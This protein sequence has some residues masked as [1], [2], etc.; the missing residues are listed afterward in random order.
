MK[1]ILLV[2]GVLFL[3]FQTTAQSGQSYTYYY[4]LGL[5]AYQ[6]KEFKKADSLFTRALEFRPVPDAFFNR[7]LCR[8]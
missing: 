8:F 2:A 7:A 1:Y 5:N 3:Y 6:F 4:D